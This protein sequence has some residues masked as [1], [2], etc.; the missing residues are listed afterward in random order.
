[1]LKEA[2]ILRPWSLRLIS[3]FCVLTYL[4]VNTL[5]CDA[6]EDLSEEA[7]ATLTSAAKDDAP[8]QDERSC[9]NHSDHKCPVDCPICGIAKLPCAPSTVADAHRPACVGQCSLL[10]SIA[11][12]T[13]VR[14][15][16]DRPPRV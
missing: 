4:F 3:F 9:P 5:H 15:C 16:L 2:L 11:Y 1:L 8:C 6:L 12:P 7:E 13:P 14:G 10:D